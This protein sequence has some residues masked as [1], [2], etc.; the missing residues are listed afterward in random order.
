MFS[1]KLHNDKYRCFLKNYSMISTDALQVGFLS[2]L[3]IVNE[4][5]NF[6]K[7][8]RFEKLSFLLNSFRFRFFVVVFIMK[9]S[10]FWKM[11]TL[12]SL[13]RVW[14]NTCSGLVRMVQGVG[15]VWIQF[16]PIVL[17]MFRWVYPWAW[18]QIIKLY[19]F[20]NPCMVG[21]IRGMEILQKL[22]R[23]S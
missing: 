6:I 14:I 3:T 21:C 10:F 9:R 8:D 11:K 1:L 13:G 7:N 23:G 4:T 12:T 18:L 19:L 2:S 5:N 16:D 20:L 22:F 17:L 15:P